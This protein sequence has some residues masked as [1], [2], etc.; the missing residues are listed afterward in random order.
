MRYVRRG[1]VAGNI[2]NYL[3]AP[4]SPESLA[5]LLRPYPDAWAGGKFQAGLPRVEVWGRH[6]VASIG[7]AV[8]ETAVVAPGSRCALVE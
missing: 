2:G 1:T 7:C 5:L 4:H 3:I 8:P 6:G